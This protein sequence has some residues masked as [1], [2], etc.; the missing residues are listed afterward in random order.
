MFDIQN[1]PSVIEEQERKD[2]EETKDMTEVEK[3]LY[4]FNKGRKVRLNK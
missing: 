2:E 1:L 4:L 3:Q